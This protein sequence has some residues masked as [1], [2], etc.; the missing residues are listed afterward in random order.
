MSDAA[1]AGPLAPSAGC[2]PA[3]YGGGDLTCINT[4]NIITNGIDGIDAPATNGNATTTNSGNVTTSGATFGIRTTT[5]IGNA[6]TNNAGNV[7]VSGSVSSFGIYT[8]TGFGAVGEAG[9]NTPPLSGGGA[10]TTNNYGNVAVIGDFSTGIFTGPGFATVN[11]PLGTANLAV[12]VSSATTNNFGN[13]SVTGFDSVGIRTTTALAVT[14]GPL[15]NSGASVSGAAIGGGDATTYNAGTVTVDGNGSGTSPQAGGLSALAVSFGT[16]GIVT[17]ASSGN[18]TTINSGIVS[19]VGSTGGTFA[20]LACGG[21]T[22]GISTNAFNGNATVIN[23]GIVSVSGP[24]NI[25]ISLFSTGDSVLA[26]SGVISAAGGIAIQF[27]NPQDPATLTLQP[28]SFIIGAINL[29]GAG[30]TVNVNAGNQNLTFNTLAGVTVTG[31]VPYIVSGDRIV[32]ID[33]T[34]FAASNSA[35]IKTTPRHVIFNT[36]RW[37]ITGPIL[38]QA[39]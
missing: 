36:A 2:T 17:G 4:G 23:A 39:P 13:V 25:G 30:D 16:I 6:T 31:N 1:A 29:I 21:S 26:N 28:G 18:A 11:A 37:D 22:V 12:T 20:C 10:A 33:P 7:S 9:I 8:A 35:G 19:V 38:N 32:S 24:N 5:N 34:G 14:Q 27:A 3:P 15:S